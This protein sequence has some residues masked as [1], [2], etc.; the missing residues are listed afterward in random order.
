MKS[1]INDIKLFIKE[2]YCR[3]ELAKVNLIIDMQG[4]E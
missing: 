4:E 1:K 2:A 3:F